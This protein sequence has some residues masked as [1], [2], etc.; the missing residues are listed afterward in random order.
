MFKVLLEVLLKQAY[1]K[2][3]CLFTRSTV[4]GGYE[5][6]HVDRLTVTKSLTDTFIFVKYYK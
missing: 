5:C 6:L 4:F 2:V 3:K 1:L